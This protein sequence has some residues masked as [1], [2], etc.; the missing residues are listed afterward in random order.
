[1]KKFKI[2]DFR[3]KVKNDVRIRYTGSK[4]NKSKSDARMQTE[5]TFKL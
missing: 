3:V 4:D 5:I 1:M 2:D